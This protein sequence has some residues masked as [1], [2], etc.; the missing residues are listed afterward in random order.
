MNKSE[1]DELHRVWMEV[2]GSA[3]KALHR[4]DGYKGS[5]NKEEEGGA[6]IRPNLLVELNVAVKNQLRNL[7]SQNQ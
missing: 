2:T 5:L 6:L 3:V 1:R 7:P 4:A